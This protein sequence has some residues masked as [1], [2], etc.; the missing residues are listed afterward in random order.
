MKFA[1]IGIGKTGQAMACYLLSR[2]HEVVMWDRDR[3]K[4]AHINANG[5]QISGV[6]SG[7]YFP[8][9]ERSIEKAVCGAKYILV[10]TTSG[11]HLPVSQLL[12]GKLSPG[13]RILIFNGNWGALEF[14]GT[15]GNECRE[16]GVLLGETGGMP[17][18]SD[19]SETGRCVLTKIKKAVAVAAIPSSTVKTMLQEIG[20]TFPFLVPGGNVIETSINNTNPILHGPIALFNISRIE[21]GEDYSFYGTAASRS[22]I[23]YVEQ[24]DQERLRIAERAG[25]KSE[26]ALDI[27]NGFWPDQY[28]NLYDAIKNNQTYI[29]GKGPTSL[30][31]RYITEDIPY[32]IAPLVQL[33]RQLGVY[34]PRLETM[35]TMFQLLLGEKLF[36][37]SPKLSQDLLEAALSLR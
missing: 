34:A 7:H 35:L 3:E 22:V 6:I 37:A 11:G 16:K 15:L 1:I 25:A 17:I 36:E 23:K 5:V 19:L 30:Q 24:A 27:L 28:E 2:G 4:A 10:M 14:Y 13:S 8:R 20:D 21:N 33:S 26:S 18:L 31:Y 12:A 32:G 9:A 29:K